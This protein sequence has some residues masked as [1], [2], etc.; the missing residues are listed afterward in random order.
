MNKDSSCS[1]WSCY[2]KIN[3]GLR[4]CVYFICIWTILPV[5]I[6]NLGCK[7]LDSILYV[8]EWNIMHYL[9]FSLRGLNGQ[10]S[11]CQMFLS[12]LDYQITWLPYF[13]TS[14]DC[15]PVSLDMIKSI[16][17]KHCHTNLINE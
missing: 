10:L 3:D 5:F 1:N 14:Y 7:E 2:I 17:Y 6:K 12:S 8:C 16:Q 9:Y 13:I 15:Y 11:M 4:K